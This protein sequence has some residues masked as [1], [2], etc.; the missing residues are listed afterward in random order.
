MYWPSTDAAHASTVIVTF[1]L[2][3]CVYGWV[4]SV[5]GRV[6]CEFSA[7]GTSVV[8][9][10]ASLRVLENCCAARL[11]LRNDAVGSP[12]SGVVCSLGALRTVHERGPQWRGRAS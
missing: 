9:T 6:V 3:V 11:R 2:G 12:R 8:S 7:S 10:C 4:G 5:L 1:L